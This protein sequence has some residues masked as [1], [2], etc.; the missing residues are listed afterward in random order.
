MK[1]R[2]LIGVSPHL[3]AAIDDVI[4]RGKMADWLALREALK[5]D[6]K[7][8][9]GTIKV[10]ETR[11]SAE[12]GALRHF[13]WLSYLDPHRGTSIQ[14]AK[15]TSGSPGAIETSVTQLIRETP[16]E[17]HTADVGGTKFTTPTDAEALRVWASLILKQN[18]TRDYQGFVALA[19]QMGAQ[20]TAAAMRTFDTYYP[21][22]SGESALQ[23]FLVQMNADSPETAQV[24]F[25]GLPVQ[26]PESP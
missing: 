26:L 12:P 24:L 17:T 18:A 9:E 8:V 3:R 14:V 16:L 1:H 21:Q 20:A 6:V 2:H 25:L 23:Q 13:F 22:P 15:I 5:R 4:G 10:C 7:T 19:K 11:V